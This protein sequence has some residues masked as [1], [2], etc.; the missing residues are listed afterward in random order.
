[1]AVLERLEADLSDAARDVDGPRSG[2]GVQANT[3]P[4]V[5]LP[6]RRSTQAPKTAAAGHR[7]ELVPGLRRGSRA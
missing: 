3:F 2:P 1:M 6:S 7:D 5:A 4:K